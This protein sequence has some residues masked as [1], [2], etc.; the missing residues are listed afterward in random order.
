MKHVQLVSKSK[1][2][3]LAAKGPVP[4]VKEPKVKKAK[5]T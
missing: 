4:G 1:L 3:I 2:P 5:A